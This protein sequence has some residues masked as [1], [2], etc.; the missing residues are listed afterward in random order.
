VFELGS[1]VRIEDYWG[2]T[3]GDR[4]LAFNGTLVQ[5]E[6]DR[7]TCKFISRALII[8]LVALG[9]L[10]QFRASKPNIGRASGRI[11]VG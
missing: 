7:F 10:R 9:G 4:S 6:R 2:G 1:F 5:Y 8:S 11:V 3:P